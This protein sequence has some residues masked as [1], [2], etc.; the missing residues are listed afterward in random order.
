MRKDITKKFLMRDG[1]CM[2]KML[3]EGILDFICSKGI[4][5]EAKQIRYDEIVF[6]NML[7]AIKFTELN[8]NNYSHISD[9]IYCDKGVFVKN[10][11]YTFR[12][13]QEI[14]TIEKPFLLGATEIT[15]DLYELAMGYNPST[16][17]GLK[18]QIKYENSSQRP[19]ENVSWYDAIMFCNKLSKSNGL[20]PYYKIESLKYYDN[21][22]QDIAYH[23]KSIEKAKVKILGGNGFRLPLTKEWKYAAKAGV[24]NQWAGT[25]NPNDVDDYAW[26]GYNSNKQTHSVA[27]KM[28]NQWGF[29]DMS[30]NVAEWCEDQG[31]TYTRDYSS[32]REGAAIIGGGFLDNPKEHANDLM[33][34]SWNRSLLR[35]SIGFRV[36]RFT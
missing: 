36:A 17:Q 19:V 25:N 2:K 35:N 6:I 28:P 27:L 21:S 8:T 14:T 20:P 18:Y 1:R 31:H 29:Y 5:R 10:I 12:I 11:E 22:T 9:M 15:Q 23:S 30:G 13:E 24:D 16:F 26:F 32:H 33:V 7:G 3:S 34:R 4:N